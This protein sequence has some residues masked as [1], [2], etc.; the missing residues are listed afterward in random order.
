M[1]EYGMQK[2]SDTKVL[3]RNN[4]IRLMEVIEARKA[5]RKKRMNAINKVE[6]NKEIE[7]EL[8]EIP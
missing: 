7:F 8:H 6:I 4:Y 1:Y 2:V 5:E 3:M